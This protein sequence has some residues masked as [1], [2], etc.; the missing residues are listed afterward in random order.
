MSYNSVSRQSTA[1]A[2]EPVGQRTGPASII[3]RRASAAAH[4]QLKQK[5]DSSR[6]AAAPSSIRQ[7]MAARQ[8]DCAQ[9]AGD[10]T[11]QPN[12]TGLPD[13]LKA[14]IEHLSGISMDHV[15]VHYNSAQPAQLNAHAYAQGSEIHVG[16]GQERHLPH[17][18]WHV[19][20]QA[21]GR[22]EPTMQ[23]K[24]GVAVNDDRGLEAEAD[25]MGA[26]ALRIGQS[27][28]RG[29]VAGLADAS[30]ASPVQAQGPVQRFADEA[31]AN[32]RKEVE[33]GAPQLDHAISQDTLGQLWSVLSTLQNLP[34]I[35]KPEKLASLMA[36]LKALYEQQEIIVTGKNA[37]LN[38]RN[39]I[40]P[41]YTD[42]FGNPGSTYDHQVK[43]DN[44]NNV[45]I[46]EQSGHLEKM[47]RA[48]RSL[49]RQLPILEK[50]A[51]IGMDETAEAFLADI[52]GDL[53]AITDTLNYLH[54]DAGTKPVFD[55][56]I[57]YSLDGRKV[58]KVPAE[59]IDV[60]DS[61]LR[62][63]GANKR[64]LGIDLQGIQIESQLRL[65]SYE[66]ESNGKTGKQAVNSIK[67]T[68]PVMDIKTTISRTAWAHIYNRH[69]IDGFS[70]DVKAVNTFWKYDPKKILLTYYDEVL[71]ELMLIIDR[72]TDLA[73]QFAA[74]KKDDE[75]EEPINEAG[76]AFFFQGKYVG[77]PGYKL[78]I[79]LQSFAPQSPEFAYAVVPSE[80]LGREPPRF[81][82]ESY[83]MSP[84]SGAESD[85]TEG[86]A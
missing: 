7:L 57:W 70:G 60:S 40:T 54:G 15:K 69:T 66:L 20:Q 8:A 25:D 51:V 63:R 50:L 55:K 31:N 79:E 28:A 24:A 83:G 6:N 36:R 46:T 72:K 9:L 38:I 32:R 5:I 37:L 11:V 27:S 39:N 3:D 58:K 80:E 86:Y 19:V 1:Q 75:F 67:H 48:I 34:G 47:D 76:T 61:R 21:Q 53:Q 45:A 13:N 22:V 2:A 74:L 4:L 44:K 43:M 64:L 16:P 26:Q 17:E 68:S 77:T 81:F 33:G 10:D 62:N 65:S 29:P 84:S 78:A 56:D 59:Y 14:G 52:N 23:M 82:D 18:A 73:K 49:V 42:T 30:S 41:G 85:D 35:K 12:N 71:A